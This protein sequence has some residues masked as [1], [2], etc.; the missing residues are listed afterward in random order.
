MARVDKRM[1]RTLWPETVE[2]EARRRYDAGVRYPGPLSAVVDGVSKREAEVRAMVKAMS[3]IPDD[4][5]DVTPWDA[6]KS[7]LKRAHF[8]VGWYDEMIR[9]VVTD[10]ADLLEGGAAWK[11]LRAQDAERR[12]LNEISKIAVQAGFA[13]AMMRQINVESELMLKATLVMFNALGIYDDKRDEGMEILST[14]LLELEAGQPLTYERKAE[15]RKFM[16]A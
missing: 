8:R 3:F 1:V 11:W 5:P 4:A 13:E 6:I 12:R 14:T 9:S 7:E 10:P 15:T 16:D 2:Q